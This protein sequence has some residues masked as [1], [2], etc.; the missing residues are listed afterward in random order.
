MSFLY[1][2]PQIQDMIGNRWRLAIPRVT[3]TYGFINSID[4]FSSLCYIV[5]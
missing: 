2:L 1:E 4:M 5:V 3:I